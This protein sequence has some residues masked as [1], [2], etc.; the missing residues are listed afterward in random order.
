MDRRHRRLAYYTACW[1]Q[2]I[3]GLP[4]RWVQLRLLREYARGEAGPITLVDLALDESNTGRFLR[5]TRDALALIERTDPRRGRRVM[6]GLR[7]IVNREGL[8]PGSYDHTL[9]ACFVD[10][11]RLHLREECEAETGAREWHLAWY[12]AMLVHEATHA[13]LHGRWFPYTR[14]TRAQTER[15]CR[16]EQR[17]F[18]AR[19]LDGDA[20]RAAALVPDFDPRQWDYSWN[21][22]PLQ[23]LRAVVARVRQANRTARK[24]ETWEADGV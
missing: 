7:Y 8:A 11:S 12:A 9:R 14:A 2:H 15:I 24:H 10:F 22:T 21:A 17:R 18:A 19:L 6:E 13:W 4:W 5:A 16:T 1:K 23:R 3:V 20:E